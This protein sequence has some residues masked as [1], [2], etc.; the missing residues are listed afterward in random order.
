MVQT[1]ERASRQ[2]DVLG[3]RRLAATGGS[4]FDAAVTPKP[5]LDYH[6][7]VPTHGAFVEA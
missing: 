7:V 3:V 1:K 2:P 4:H 6:R 5:R